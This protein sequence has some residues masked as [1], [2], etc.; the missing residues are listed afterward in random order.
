MGLRQLRRADGSSSSGAPSKRAGGTVGASGGE[1]SAS[2]RGGGKGDGAGGARRVLVE[3]L[4]SEAAVEEAP[5][6]ELEDEVD[7]ERRLIV[8]LPRVSAVTDLDVQIGRQAVR[9]HAGAAGWDRRR[10]GKAWSASRVDQ[11][12]RINNDIAR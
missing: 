3:E 1:A 2:A 6:H 8:R 9:L 7:G 11:H 5:E 12:G 4:S 10:A